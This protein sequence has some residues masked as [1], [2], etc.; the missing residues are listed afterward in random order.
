MAGCSRACGG[1]YRAQRALTAVAR[2]AGTRA[3]FFHGRGGSISRGAG[4]THRFLKGTPPGALDFSL[5]VTEQGETIAQ[6]YANR[7]TAAFHVELTLANVLRASVLAERAAGGRDPERA[8][9]ERTMDTLAQTSF[10]AYRALVERPGFVAFFRQAT[11]ID[12]LEESRIGSRPARRTGQASLADLRAIPWV[13]A[14]GQARFYLSGWYG[15]GTALERLERAEPG[16]FAALGRHLLGWA[17]LH[18]ALSNAATS[19]AWADPRA[20]DRVRR[21]RA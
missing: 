20:H 4:P 21:P 6:K 15:V 14:W 16:A 12:V 7:V 13:F 5:R 11:P 10:A 17:P 9:L 18:Y 19:V 2:E 1:L 8:L 3:R